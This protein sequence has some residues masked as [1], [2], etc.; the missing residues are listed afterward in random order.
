M[1]CEKFLRR[2]LYLEITFLPYFYK[3][4]W[5]KNNN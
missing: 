1:L 4:N 3:N 2:I 5:F